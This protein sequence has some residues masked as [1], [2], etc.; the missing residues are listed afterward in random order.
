MNKHEPR[1]VIKDKS[2]QKDENTERQK[3]RKTKQH[4]TR[5]QWLPMNNDELR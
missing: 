3:D 2:G 4:N 1:Q 5:L